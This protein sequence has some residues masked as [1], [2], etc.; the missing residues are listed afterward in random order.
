MYGTVAALPQYGVLIQAQGQLYLHVYKVKILSIN[1]AIF[2]GP[3]L[4][5]QIHL[6]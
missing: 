4:T 2:E 6:G 1:V 3:Y 5:K